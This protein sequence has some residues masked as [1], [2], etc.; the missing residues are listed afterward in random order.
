MVSEAKQRFERLVAE[1]YGKVK[2]FALFLCRNNA[3]AEDLTQEAF[4]RAYRNYDLCKESGSFENWILKITKHLY[5]DTQRRKARRYRLAPL[6][7]EGIT[8]DC[9]EHLADDRA[10]PD[11]VL[12]A[13]TWDEHLLEALGQLDP[14][15]REL[16]WLICVE[17]TP[18][19]EV[20]AKLN[21]P[22]GSVKSRMFR[23][24]RRLRLAYTRRPSSEYGLPCTA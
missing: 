8:E 6:S 11:T 24:V 18:Y 1:Y 3:D 23:A 14:Q 15:Q 7:H 4:A 21:I 20:A 17:Q 9:A 10:R 16:L 5:L 19:A 22:V 13:A 12:M 2:R